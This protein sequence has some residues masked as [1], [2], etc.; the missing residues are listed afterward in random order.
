[1]LFNKQACV[2]V[3]AYPRQKIEDLEADRQRLEEQNNNLEM[4]LER[5]HLQV[6]RRCFLHLF[7]V[8]DSVVWR[9]GTTLVAPLA[10]A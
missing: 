7:S 4:R 6:G 8:M 9:K 3:C 5:H 10:A 2:C 1:M